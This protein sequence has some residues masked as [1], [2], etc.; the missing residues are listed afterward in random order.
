MLAANK[1]F[2]ADIKAL[3]AT[4]LT[5][6]DARL[7]IEAYKALPPEERLK[8]L[9][10]HYATGWIA[11]MLKALSPQDAADNFVDE[12]RE[13]LRWVEEA[14]TRKATGL[15]DEDMAELQAKYMESK[16]TK[17][18]EEKIEKETPKG[19]APAPPTAE[20][21]AEA[22]KEIVS[23]S[24]VEKKTEAELEWLKKKEEEKRKWDERAKA[25]IK[26]ITSL[27]NSK[28]PELKVKE[29]SF[30]AN[31]EDIERRGKRVIAMTGTGPDGARQLVIGYAFV[32]TAEVN[33]EYVMSIVV[34]ELFG[35]PEFGSYGTEYLL[36][37]YDTA[38]TK[39]ADYTQ[40]TGEERLKEI[41]NFAYQGTEIFS[42]LRGFAYHTPISDEDRE[43]HK[44][45]RLVSVDPKETVQHRIGL[46]RK[47]WDPK[48]S[49]ALVRGLYKR[50]N[51]DPRLTPEAIDAF[52][53]GVRAVFGKEAKEILK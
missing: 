1:T 49:P 46:I 6:S 5:R 37:L 26:S 2:L 43:K 39:M 11:N 34:H 8:Y 28:Y 24:S 3:R 42:L 25:V 53:D 45:K 30:N 18:A 27:A 19:V 12:V 7:A 40:P 32:E 33:P 17:L 23:K 4:G 16:R 14:E 10:K 52:R 38:A 13:I 9:E 21:K 35:H 41:D 20:Q 47:N 50:F 15:S 31:F 48:L 29:S 51:L 36:N 22:H 44:G